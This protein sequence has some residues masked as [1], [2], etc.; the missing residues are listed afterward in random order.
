MAV[1][2]C[3][4]SSDNSSRCK[5]GRGTCRGPVS[6]RGAKALRIRLNAAA[7]TAIERVAPQRLHREATRVERDVCRCAL[8]GRDPG[9]LVAVLGAAAI[10]PPAARELVA[11]R[12][13]QL[14]ALDDRDAGIRAEAV[15]VG[16]AA[17]AGGG[18]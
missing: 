5:R 14:V 10:Q 18:D 4:S 11:D 13:G 2:R 8:A 3:P 17:R 6:W 1:A 12:L 9:A 16:A 15:E 7:R